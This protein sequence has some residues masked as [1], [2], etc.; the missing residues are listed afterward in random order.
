MS[1]VT[2][3]PTYLVYS[4]PGCDGLADT[5]CAANTPVK[6]RFQRCACTFEKFADGNDNIKLSGFE[7][8]NI[9]R[10][11]NVLFVASFHNNNTTMQA[12]HALIVLRSITV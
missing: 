4:G 7:P 10:G 6:Y 1:N 9:V 3:K 12:L 8:A 5:I 11:A 2:N